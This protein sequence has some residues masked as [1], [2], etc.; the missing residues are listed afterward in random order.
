MNPSNNSMNSSQPTQNDTTVAATTYTDPFAD[1]TSGTQPPPNTSTNKGN[2]TG[3]DLS[4]FFGG[5]VSSS[6]GSKMNGNAPNTNTSGSTT[7]AF[8]FDLS[9]SSQV[10]QSPAVAT[11]NAANCHATKVD[12]VVVYEF[13]C[14]R[15]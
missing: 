3:N 12:Y 7:S 11:T 14:I 13:Q 9:G 6:G 1:I 2:D 15:Y 10:S 8:G 5:N 4:A